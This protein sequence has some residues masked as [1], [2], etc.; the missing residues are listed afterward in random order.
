MARPKKEELSKAVNPAENGAT[1]FVSGYV[2]RRSTT[3]DPILTLKA[4]GYEVDRSDILS[5]LMDLFARRWTL[6]RRGATKWIWSRSWL[7]LLSGFWTRPL[8]FPGC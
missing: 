8:L 2:R 6:Q 7:P 1:L 3:V 4:S 5:T